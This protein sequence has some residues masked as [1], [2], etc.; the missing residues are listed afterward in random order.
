M[1]VEKARPR[2][3]PDTLPNEQSRRGVATYVVVAGRDSDTP[4]RNELNRRARFVRVLQADDGTGG[5][6]PHQPR[7]ARAGCRAAVARRF[8]RLRRPRRH[9]AVPGDTRRGGEAV[10]VAG[11]VYVGA[12]GGSEV[13]LRM[14]RLAKHSGG[15]RSAGS[16]EKAAHEDRAGFDG[17]QLSPQRSRGISSPGGLG[18][19]DLA[20][21]GWRRPTRDRA[22]RPGDAAV[23]YG[24]TDERRPRAIR[25]IAHARN[26]RGASAS[27][28]WPGDDRHGRRLCRRW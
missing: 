11:G 16:A 7:N 17:P 18:T 23:P 21:G 26:A 25:R 24:R 9:P 14:P 22:A 6:Q 20:R 19:S 10:G 13:V 12:R 8:G 1:L 27:R 5:V 2:V 4:E 15:E 3:V 28:V